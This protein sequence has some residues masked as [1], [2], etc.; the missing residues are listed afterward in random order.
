MR[1]LLGVP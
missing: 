1:L